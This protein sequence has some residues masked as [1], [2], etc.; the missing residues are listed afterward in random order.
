MPTVVPVQVLKELTA[1][2]R[3]QM[4]LCEESQDQQPSLSPSTAQRRKRQPRFGHR[5]GSG[6]L[7][8]GGN[9]CAE[10]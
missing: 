6:R 3:K 9:A 2:R 10:V 5:E 8:G 4:I 7:P 1:W